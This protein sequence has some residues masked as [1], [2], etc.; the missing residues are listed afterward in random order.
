MTSLPR[1]HLLL[2]ALPNAMTSVAALPL[3]LFLPSFYADDLGVPLATVGGAIAASR[4][5]DVVTDPW[6]GGW[7]DR[8]RTR[9][10][11]RKP[12]LLAGTPLLALAVWQ[13]FVPPHDADGWHLLLWSCVLY[14]GFTIVDLP[15]RAWGAE[16]S[17]DYS[18][19]SRIAAWREALGTA[20]QVTLLAAL[21]FGTAAGLEGASAELRAMAVAIVSLL[22]LCVL[23]AVLGVPEPPP[24]ASTAA[25]L[26]RREAVRLVLQNPAFGRMLG[27]ALLFV[28]GVVVQGTLHRL[29]LTHVIDAPSWF[30]PMI[31]LENVATLLAIPLWQALGRRIGKHRA[32]ALAALWLAAFSLALPAFGRGDEAL[33]VTWIVLRGSS[34][35][36]ILF[37]ANAMAADVVDL[38]RVRSGHQRTGVF[39]AAWGVVNKLA[40]ALGVLGGTALPAA[41]GFD[42]SAG[43]TSPE[44]SLRVMQIYG[45]VPALAMGLGA[46]FLW[47]FPIDEARQR[48]L[49]ATIEE[50]RAA[51]SGRASS[52]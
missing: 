22:P 50:A 34:F 4:V 28:G 32:A 15:Y 17:D 21:V 5:L 24:G 45:W 11:R 14:L 37:L 13:L 30:A 16:L 6:I 19:R 49:R 3:A 23:A 33:F 43:A 40:V 12:F 7:S 38:D 9:W 52:A 46:A 2:Y 31:L 1:L 29:V 8:L 48:A 39:F 26:R 47:G 51:S 35:A 42:P 10:G 44:V 36:S 25:P 41:V 18:E 20:G 27:A